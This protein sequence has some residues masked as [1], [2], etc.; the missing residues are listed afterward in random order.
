MFLPSKTP[1]YSVLL[2][3]ESADLDSPRENEIHSDSILQKK[4]FA[5]LYRICT[6]IAVVCVSAVAFVTIFFSSS[7]KHQFTC[8]HP[9]IRPE[10]RTLSHAEKTS[11]IAAAHCLTTTPSPRN[12]NITVH[13]DFSYLHSRTGNYSHNAAPFLPWH[14]YFLHAYEH[15]L[16][17]Y[18]HYTGPLPYW[19]WSLDYRNLIESPIWDTDDGFGPS[20]SSFT[21]VANGRCVD[22]GPFANWMPT[23]YEGNYHPHCLSRGFQDETIV[24][25][26]GNLTVRPDIL[27]GVI[28]DKSEYFDF[29]L[30]VETMSHLTIP[31]IV[32]GDFSKVTAPNDPVFFLHHAQVDRVWWSW[33]GVHDERRRK[34][35]GIARYD[36]TAEASVSDVLDLGFILENGAVVTVEDVMDAEGSLLCYRYDTSAMSN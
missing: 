16:K 8:T 23:Y 5:G 20:G 28:R 11:Y 7:S 18:C 34:Y 9:R 19:D 12:S 22:Q 1:S 6:A 10:W 3:S 13:D 29:L 32:Q 14:R 27:Q 21:S 24:T 15:A 26:V 4:R 33:Q 35:N 30:A 25:R 2:N 36:S 31:Y 17:E